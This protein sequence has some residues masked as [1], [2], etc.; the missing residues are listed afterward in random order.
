MLIMKENMQKKI[1]VCHNDNEIDDS[2]Y[3]KFLG[4]E[5]RE[6]VYISNENK[7]DF[8]RYFPAEGENPEKFNAIMVFCELNWERHCRS[9]FWG[10]EF[11]KS[12]RIKDK[13]KLPVLF[14][15]YSM[16]MSEIVKEAPPKNN[17]IT[18]YGL[19][20]HFVRFPA[21]KE[22]IKMFD[23]MKPLSELEMADLAHYCSLYGMLCAIRHDL[24]VGNISDS[25][26]HIIKLLSECPN[27]EPLI[28]ELIAIPD[29]DID[30]IKSF[31]N[32]DLVVNALNGHEQNSTPDN[33]TPINTEK[34]QVLLLDDEYE[35]ENFQELIKE[36]AKKNVF[37]H[38][39]SDP[40]KALKKVKNSKTEFSV[41]LCDY[42]LK[43][44]EGVLMYPQGYT[45]IE[46]ANELG[47]YKFIAFSNM[48]RD[49][50]IKVAEKINCYI[51]NVNKDLMLSEQGRPALIERIIELAKRN[52][53]DKLMNITDDKIFLNYYRYIMTHKFPELKIKDTKEYISEESKKLI[54][55]FISSFCQSGEKAFN[56]QLYLDMRDITDSFAQDWK[57]TKTDYD[58]TTPSKKSIVNKEPGEKTPEK[59]DVNKF[60]GRMIA[61]RFAIYLY[62]CFATFSHSL[63]FDRTLIVSHSK[64]FEIPN[65][66]EAY[67]KQT[68]LDLT[69]ND[70]IMLFTT[71]CHIPKPVPENHKKDTYTTS[72]KGY[73]YVTNH[74]KEYDPERESKKIIKKYVI[75]SPFEYDSKEKK[76]TVY[77]ID[78][79]SRSFGMLSESLWIKSSEFKNNPLMNMTDDEITFFKKYKDVDSWLESKN[80]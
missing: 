22:E 75:D 8:Y 66:F 43:N 5:G 12:F 79:N 62:Y 16:D 19:G 80:S 41:I 70:Y 67:L 71:H 29:Q 45:F 56:D 64:T 46:K 18:T 17:I 33:D 40:Q 65:D 31:C 37:I 28:V 30:S 10:I 42:K 9:E 57:K 77:L 24:N 26:E 32:K 36:A 4:N 49:F 76:L 58:L 54:D 27:T 1:L 74:Q 44:K 59:E 55:M 23:E 53:S 2:V 47:W 25:K 48:P 60:I 52:S 15:T 13:I 35:K 7:N 50:R 20:H 69:T 72:V 34:Y 63:K 14:F 38:C 73:P 6:F 11:V 51:E 78:Q 21:D 68:W 61:R 3:Q 39:E